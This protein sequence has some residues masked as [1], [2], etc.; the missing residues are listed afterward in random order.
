MFYV[1]KISLELWV[2]LEANNL[3]YYIQRTIIQAVIKE[4]GIKRFKNPLPLPDDII[5]TLRQEWA[6]YL[7]ERWS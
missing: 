2:S 4:E 1:S 6:A 5:H 3:K 7:L